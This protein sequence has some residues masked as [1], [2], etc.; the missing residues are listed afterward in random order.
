M[1]FMHYWHNVGMPNEDPT[2]PPVLRVRLLTVREVAKILNIPPSSLW[3]KAR[4]GTVPCMRVGKSWRF[5]PTAIEQFIAQADF[6]PALV[7]A[8]KERS[9]KE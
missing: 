3:Y 1:W 4:K 7:P 2:L 5:S 8:P 6:K 9:R